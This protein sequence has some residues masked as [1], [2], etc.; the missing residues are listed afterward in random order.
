MMDR[1]NR[2]LGAV[3]LLLLV[4]TGVV[5]KPWQ[6]DQ[7]AQTQAT[8][9][10]LFPALQRQFELARLRVTPPAGG[11]PIHIEKVLDGGQPRWVVRDAFDH[12][13]H[14]DKIGRLIESMR[15]LQTRNLESLEESS[16][17][18]Y[19]IRSGEGLEVELWADDGE[20]LG[21]LVI[22]ALRGQD[23]LSGSAPIVQFYVR[24]GDEAAVYRSDT[25]YFPADDLAGWCDTR[26]LSQ[27]QESE[28]RY[29]QRADVRGEES[30]RIVIDPAVPKSE[31]QD[32]AQEAEATGRWRMVTPESALV[33]DFAAESWW[34]TMQGLEADEVL[35][36]ATDAAGLARFG[37][38]TDV[39]EIG[40]GEGSFAIELGDALPDGRRLA[41]VYGLPH[42]YAL[43]SFDVEQLL[44]PRAAMLQ[45]D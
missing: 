43:S 42:L 38:A 4:L 3:F 8:I 45:L 20:S 30:W 15:G 32:S 23:V 39:L 37:D 24:R 40:L 9:R 35:G 26:F 31:A 22:G 16:H 19:K 33:P 17:A 7:F 14:L 6:G 1:R 41:R 18:A 5:E 29:L 12:P 27:A 10:P 44:Q 11:D 28:L 25:V 34:F 36:L 2:V 13:A 21:H